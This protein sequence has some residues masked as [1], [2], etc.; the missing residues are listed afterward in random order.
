ML[1]NYGGIWS[2]ATVYCNRPVDQ[3]LDKSMGFFAF[4]QPVADR[5]VASWFLF[6]ERNN[7]IIDRWYERVLKFWENKRLPFIWTSILPSRYRRKLRRVDYYWFHELFNQMYYSEV[8]VRELWD[9]T[10]KI[11]CDTASRQG[12]HFLVPYQ[13][14][15]TNSYD[16]A[17]ALKVIKEQKEKPPVYKLTS[18]VKDSFVLSYLIETVLEF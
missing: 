13:T 5:L 3:W 17:E 10:I 7:L 8:A 12:P 16:S 14:Y 9:S 6:G 2:D 15:L 1:K 4:S 18:G 11:G